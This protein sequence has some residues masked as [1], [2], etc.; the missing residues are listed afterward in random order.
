MTPIHHSKAGDRI[1]FGLSLFALLWSFGVL[2][3]GGFTTSINAGMAFL[4]WPL[5]NGSINP[6]GWLTESDKFAEHSHRLAAT[7]LGIL[8]ILIAIAHR[9]RETRRGVRLAAYGTLALVVAQGG[10][11]ALRVLLDQLNVGGDS[12]I[13]ALSFAIGHAINAQLTVALLACVTLTHTRLWQRAA[14][15]PAPTQSRRL[16]VITL[17]LLFLVILAAAVMRQNRV[18]LWTTGEM[19]TLWGYF[20][21]AAGEGWM[22]TINLLHRGGA[23]LAG[24]SIILFANSLN[25]LQLAFNFRRL[26]SPQW[27]AGVSIILVAILTL[28]ILLGVLAIDRPANPHPRTIHLMVAAALLAATACATLLCHRGTKDNA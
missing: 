1:L 5:S 16:G 20:I 14:E 7:G 15:D 3:A 10:L 8:T 12:N 4:D 21:P 9:L 25:G 6:P 23:L 26:P 22:W 2:Q 17:V 13:K 24:I 27:A 28:Q 11:G 19:T 18:T